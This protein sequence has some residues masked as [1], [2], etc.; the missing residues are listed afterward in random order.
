VPTPSHHQAAGAPRARTRSRAHAARGATLLPP[1]PKHLQPQLRQL[2][3]SRDPGGQMHTC[4][5][6]IQLVLFGMHSRT[7]G[8]FVLWY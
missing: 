7:L 4:V 8:P 1:P 2:L 3:Q 6:R 5:K